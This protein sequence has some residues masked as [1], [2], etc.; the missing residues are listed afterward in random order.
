VGLGRD[1]HDLQASCVESLGP[2][3]SRAACG[4][5]APLTWFM[6]TLMTSDMTSRVGATV[7]P[8]ELLLGGADLDALNAPDGQFKFV[9]IEAGMAAKSLRA[10]CRR[11]TTN[12]NLKR[13]NRWLDDF[14]RH[15]ECGRSASSI[16]PKMVR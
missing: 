16:W 13:K 9:E 8:P 1:D 6:V 3:L 11:L 4:F 14:A 12:A 15:F 5:S 10:L 7:T 2:I